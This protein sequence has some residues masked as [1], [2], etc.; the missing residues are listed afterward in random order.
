MVRLFIYII[1]INS[2]LVIENTPYKPDTVL[3]GGFKMNNSD[4]V[5][6]YREFIILCM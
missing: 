2:N 4:V 5:P 3:G 1:N 6:T